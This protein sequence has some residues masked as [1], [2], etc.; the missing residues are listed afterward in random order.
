MRLDKLGTFLNF[1]RISGGIIPRQTLQFFVT[2]S[3]GQR[4]TF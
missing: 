4:Y 1:S 2:D 3:V